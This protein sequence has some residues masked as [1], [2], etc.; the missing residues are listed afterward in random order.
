MSSRRVQTARPTPTPSE[1]SCRPCGV[2]WRCSTGCSARPNIWQ[3]TPFSLADIAA[4]PILHYLHQFP[5]GMA[6]ASERAN[7]EAYFTTVRGKAKRQGDGPRRPC[8]RLP[9]PGPGLR[10][11]SGASI[12]LWLQAIGARLF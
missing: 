6:L 1:R 10:A 2:T 12:A 4:L 9:E 5:E 8:R 11:V 3:A 7:L